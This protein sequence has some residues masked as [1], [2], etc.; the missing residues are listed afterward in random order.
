MAL[1]IAGAADAKAV[2]LLAA[3]V[4]DQLAGIAVMLGEGKSISC[5]MS[6]R[7]ARIFSIWFSSIRSSMVTTSSLVEE[8]QVRCAIAGI[9][10]VSWIFDAISTVR[11]EVLPPAP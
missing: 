9:P 10:Y 7:S 4:L 5:G 2:A 8:T 3:D 11:L 6:P 1:R